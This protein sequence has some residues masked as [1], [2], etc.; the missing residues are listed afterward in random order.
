M[1]TALVIGK[2]YPPHPGHLHLL[3]AALANHVRVVVLCLGAQSDSYS[4]RRRL[5]AL[6]EDAHAD[7]IDPRRIIGRAGFDHTPF[8][9]SDVTVWAAHVEVFRGFLA[10]CPYFDSLVTSEAYGPELAARLGVPHISC[11]PDRQALPISA[12]A[13]RA[14]PI[15]AWGVLGPG[16]RRMLASRIVL[17]GAESTGTTTVAARL[18]ERLRARG[19]AWTGTGLVEEYGRVVT[20]RKQRRSPTDDGLLPLSVEWTSVDF[21]EIVTTQAWLEDQATAAGGPALICDTDAFAT[22]V[23]ERRYLGSAARL[24]PAELGCADVYLVTHHDGVPFAQD[25]MRDGEHLR[26]T[27]TGQFVR[28]LVTHERPFTVLTGS[29]E[30]RLRLAERITDQTVAHRL[31]FSD[32]I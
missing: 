23:W 1:T 24:D 27:M 22:P 25:G 30:D 19:G 31:S 21:A 2:F 20:E 14:D 7:G 18:A 16:T 11:D 5:A 3:R 9:L 10:D 28:Q 15:A 32:P 26:A 6:I 12:S 17:L 29:L 13:I 8:D 4:P